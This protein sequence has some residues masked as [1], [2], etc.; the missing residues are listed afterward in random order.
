MWFKIIP[1]ENESLLSPSF[2][3]F[4]SLFSLSK[5]FL[6]GFFL[7]DGSFVTSVGIV[8]L[9]DGENGVVEGGPHGEGKSEDEYLVCPTVV[10][11]LSK[12]SPSTFDGGVGVPLG[13]D[14]G[15]TA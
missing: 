13:D 1:V 2:G 12:E 14:L 15:L 10:E 8:G 3:S 7:S 9:I 4:G 11:Q 6:V 5:L